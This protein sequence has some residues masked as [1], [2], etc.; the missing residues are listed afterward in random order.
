MRNCF[1]RR[2]RSVAAAVWTAVFAMMICCT[3]VN[4]QLGFDFVPGDQQMKTRVDTVGLESNAGIKTYVTLMDSML[5]GNL[6]YAYVGQTQDAVFGVTTAGVMMQYL[7]YY[8]KDTLDYGFGFNIVPDSLCFITDMSYLSGDSTRQQ[9]INVYE[10]TERLYSDSSYYNGVKYEQYID[11]NNPLFSFTLDGKRKNDEVDTLWVINPD[12][13]IDFT[14][15]GQAY[16]DKLLED[17]TEYHTDSLF[18]KK[19]KGLCLLPAATSPKDGALYKWTLSSTYLVLYSHDYEPDTPIKPRDTI[20][21]VYHFDDDQDWAT[22]CASVATVRHDYAGTP[23][24]PLIND[25]INPSASVYVQGMVGVTTQLEFT[26]GLFEAIEALKPDPDYTIMINQAMLYAT[27]DFGPGASQESGFDLYLDALNA[28]PERLGSYYVYRS[29]SPIADYYYTAEANGYTITY[30]GYL[31]RKQGFYAMDI[32]SYVQNGLLNPENRRRY[33]LA[34]EAY[35][36]YV[37]SQ[38]TLNGYG[39]TQPLKLKLTYTLI[40]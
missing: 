3:T 9:T 28:A 18:Q 14:A 25:T 5:A 17:T 34:P 33:T 29:L 1:K 32:T 27:C 24:Q 30:D 7:P 4:D 20:V 6:G 12:R 31:N 11:I 22:P 19:F 39:S 36:V 13:G 15:N 38:V 16:V 10:V 26:E 21:M 37:P 40:K 35:S 2:N 8:Y 23:I